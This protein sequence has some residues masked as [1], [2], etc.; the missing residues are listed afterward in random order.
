[1][2]LNRK[3]KQQNS[4][5]NGTTWRHHDIPAIP[6]YLIGTRPPGTATAGSAISVR[7][8]STHLRK[9]LHCTSTCLSAKGYAP[10][11]AATNVSRKTTP[12]KHRISIPCWPNGSC[13]V[14]CWA[15]LLSPSAKYT[16]VAVPQRS[17]VRRS[18]NGS[19]TGCSRGATCCQSRH[20]L[21]RPIR[22]IPLP[23][24][25]KPF[26]MP[27][28]GA[29]VLVYRISIPRCNVLSTDGKP[30]LMWSG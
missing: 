20:F 17:S 2:C 6:Q 8:S 5:L 4:W 19:W 22:Q 7:H 16:S 23:P 12:S 24:T 13:T 29:S 30:K 25:C 1:L 9:V 18:S 3:L 27:D 14:T 28:S 26:M 15:Q 10:T 21:S 11:A